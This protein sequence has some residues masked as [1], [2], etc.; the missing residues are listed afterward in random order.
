MPELVVIEADQQG[1]RGDRADAALEHLAAA[2]GR[3]RRRPTRSPT[4]SARC[5]SAGCSTACSRAPTRSTTTSPRPCSR[6]CTWSTPASRSTASIAD[7]TGGSP[8]VVV[9]DGG[10]PTGML[11][12]SDLLE[13]LAHRAERRVTPAGHG[14]RAARRL[15]IAAQGYATPPAR[16][17][18]PGRG[19]GDH[20]PARRRAARLDLGRR[21]RP[22]ADARLAGRRLSAEAPCRSCSA[23]AASSSTGRTRP[24][25]CRSPTGRSTASVMLASTEHPWWGADPAAASRSWPTSVMAEIRERG[26]LGSRA[27]R[28]RGPGGMWSYKPAKRV[29]EALWTPGRARDRRTAGLPAAV[30]PARAGDPRRRA[31]RAGAGRDR[32]AARADRCAP[33]SARGALTESGVVEHNRLRGGDRPH[34]RPRRRAGR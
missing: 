29:L 16:A 11:T 2:G 12:R 15:A 32:D 31:R 23:A 1:R 33:S 3:G 6:R 17:A 9:A 21:P 5:T 27:L 25:C 4:W 26:P 22:P 30:R 18:A 8:A 19:R 14:R 7:L 34:P 10:R 13:Y 20:R 28:G 24:A